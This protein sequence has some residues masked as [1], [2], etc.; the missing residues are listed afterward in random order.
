MNCR[1]FLKN[2]ISYQENIIDPTLK[3]NMD[4]HVSKCSK[5]REAFEVTKEMADVLNNVEKVERSDYFW[6]NLHNDIINAK[7]GYTIVTKKYHPEYKLSFWER[8]LKP[9][10]IGF[11]FGILL[12]SI[13]FYFDFK[14]GGFW[15]QKE[16][17]SAG[18]EVDF[19]INEHSLTENSNIFSHGELATSLISFQEDNK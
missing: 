4:A 3:S 18:K 17:N 7:V 2:I 12:F 11:S 8:F 10:M 9:A 14:S 5:C 6:N 16:I 15:S 13:Y 19:Y 1:K